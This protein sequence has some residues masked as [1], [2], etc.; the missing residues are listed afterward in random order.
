MKPPFSLTSIIGRQLV[1]ENTE[2]DGSELHVSDLAKC[3]RE[4][5][6]RRHGGAKVP[7]SPDTLMKWRYGHL[8]EHELMRLAQPDLEAAGW[9]LIHGGVVGYTHNGIAITGHPDFRIM[10][11]EQKKIVVFD[12][13]TTTFFPTKEPYGHG[14]MGE[15]RFRRIREAPKSPQQQYQI[16]TNA[17]AVIEQVGHP[18]FKVGWGV[19]VACRESGMMTDFDALEKPDPDQLHALMIEY[20]ALTGPEAI[21]PPDPEPPEFTFNAKG[22]SWAHRYCRALDCPLNENP[23]ALGLYGTEGA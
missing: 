10:H 7:P 9:T 11:P 1:K 8:I 21:T 22:D 12:A 15:Q 4:V 17:Y 2:R 16:Q 20:D 13:K 18:D 19:L 5:W 6:E 3:P 14:P 23:D